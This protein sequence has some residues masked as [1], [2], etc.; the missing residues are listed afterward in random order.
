MR[1]LVTGADGMLGSNLV[2]LLLEREH[3][4]NVLVHPASRSTTLNGLPVKKF[5][6]DILSPDSIDS[7][8]KGAD[9]LIHAAASTSVWPSRSEKVRRINIDGTRNMIDA[10]LKHQ[11]RRMIYIGS[12]SSVDEN[13]LV[14]G[15]YCFSCHQTG[16]DYI[17]SK[18]EALQLVIEAFRTRGLPAIAI[19]PTFMIG[20]FDSLPSSGKMILAMARKK[21]KFYTRGGKNFVCVRDV[22]IAVSNA[23]ELGRLGKIYI[24]G[25]ENL[26]FKDFFS[27]AAIILNKPAPQMRVPDWL[28]QSFGFVGSA[29]GYLLGREPLLS[30]HMACISCHSHFNF[31]DDARNELR[32]P[33]TP[34][35]EGILECYKWFL[36]NS[37][38]RG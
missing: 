32:M 36:E 10:A 21:V 30:W 2:R 16:L 38:L 11:V 8:I 24:T 25:N 4:V 31:N 27:R 6:G 19:L 17:D 34:I 9:I 3:E 7:A 1:I 18:Y 22:A 20:P 13:Q 37:Y 28:V 5:T 23:I 14:D 35:E 33:R 29:N 12:A 26:S 15:E